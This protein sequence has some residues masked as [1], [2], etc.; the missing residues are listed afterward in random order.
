MAQD[1]KRKGSNHIPI[2][3]NTADTPTRTRPAEGSTVWPRDKHAPQAK[4]KTLAP[5]IVAVVNRIL[6]SNQPSSRGEAIAA[7]P[8]SAVTMIDTMNTRSIVLVNREAFM[9]LAPTALH[10]VA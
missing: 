1:N 6:N 7:T 9:R 5:A 8:A 10:R 4:P 3:I 2:R